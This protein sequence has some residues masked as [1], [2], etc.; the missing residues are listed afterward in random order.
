M[1]KL[2]FA[3]LGT[4]GGNM[5]S[6]LL[7]KGHTVTGRA[8]HGDAH[9]IERSPGGGRRHR[10]E[11]PGRLGRGDPPMPGVNGHKRTSEGSLSRRSVYRL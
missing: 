2:G 6:R 3:G 7:D 10:G 4:M 11:V 1:A 9:A 8:P 5:V